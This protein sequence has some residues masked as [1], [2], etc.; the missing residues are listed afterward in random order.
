MS[1]DH[2]VGRLEGKMD[3]MLTNQSQFFERHESEHNKMWEKLDSHS[4][5]ING[6]KGAIA[7]MSTFCI[8]VVA[9]FERKFL[10]R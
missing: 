6:L 5:W 2:D 8:F 10:G 9:W 3:L 7:I 1:I 4:R